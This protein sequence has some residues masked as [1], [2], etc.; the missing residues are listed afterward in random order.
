MGRDRNK[1]E[2]SA[3]LAGMLPIIL[4]DTFPW[5]FLDINIFEEFA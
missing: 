5:D 3:F 2:L 4:N 1:E